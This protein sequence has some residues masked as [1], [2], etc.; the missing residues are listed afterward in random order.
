MQTVSALKGRDYLVAAAALAEGL[1]VTFYPYLIETC[2]D[3]TWQLE[4]FPT[5]REQAALGEQ[6]DP[7]DLEEALDIRG[8]SEEAGDF[9]LIWVEPPP[10][11]QWTAY[12]VPWCGSR[13]GPYTGPGIFRRWLTYMRASTALPATSGMKAATLTSTST[14]RC[15]WRSRRMAQ[16]LASWARL[17]HLGSPPQPLAS[18]RRA[19]NESEPMGRGR[20]GD[21]L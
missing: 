8:S 7:T 16:A 3:E 9:G 12:H 1:A 10:Q 17:S 2:A 18:A 14:G 19:R 4:R 13:Q 20:V 6:M 21:D 11:F 5:P 15:M